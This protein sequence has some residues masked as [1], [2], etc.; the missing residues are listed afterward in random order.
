[1]DGTIDVS[2]TLTVACTILY[3]DVNGAE[4]LA[5]NGIQDPE[6]PDNLHYSLSLDA[7]IIS[8]IRIS[9]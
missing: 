2:A 6:F 8:N 3:M 5:F 9:N 1:M 7:A 4:N